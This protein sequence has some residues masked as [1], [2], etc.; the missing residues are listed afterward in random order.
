M[1]DET[2]PVADQLAQLP[3]RRRGDPPLRQA[4]QPQHRGQVTGAA[5][6]VLDP[7]VPPVVAQRVRQVHVRAQF[8]EQVRRPVLALRRLQDHLWARA[9]LGHHLRQFEGLARDAGAPKHFPVR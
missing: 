3:H 1:G 4:A 5:L 9:G 8:G 2:G 7:P 6:V